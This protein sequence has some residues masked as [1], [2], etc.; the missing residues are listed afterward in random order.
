MSKRDTST[1][2]PEVEFADQTDTPVSEPTFSSSD[3]RLEVE[4]QA[5]A[6]L[7]ENRGLF[8]TARIAAALTDYSEGY[9]RKRLHDLAD[10]DDTDVERERRSKEIYGV[11]IGNSFVVLTDSKQQ[12]LNIVKNH[13]GS[14]FSAAKS[15]SKEELRDFIIDEIAV[16]EVTSSTDKLYFG[17]PA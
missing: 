4:A 1:P 9:V 15:M 7:E 14:K 17:I 5:L 3:D 16:Q 8:L 6:V 10:S 11:I 12:L 13:R 2:D